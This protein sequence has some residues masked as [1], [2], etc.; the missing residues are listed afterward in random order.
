MYHLGYE[1]SFKK[2]FLVENNTNITHLRNDPCTLLAEYCP[3]IFC[4]KNSYSV[5]KFV[6][7]G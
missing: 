7:F 5:N 3:V 1:I 6:K 2:V 4:G